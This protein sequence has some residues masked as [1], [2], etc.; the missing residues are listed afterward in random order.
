MIIGLMIT[1]FRGQ[2]AAVLYSRNNVAV[3]EMWGPIIDA[4]DWIDQMDTYGDMSGVPAIVLHVNSPGGYVTP[5]QELCRRVQKL[6]EKDGKV[7]VA[8]FD[9][10]A[11]SG[12]YYAAAGADKIVCSPG[13]MTG[14]IGVYMKHMEASELFSKIGV[15]FDTIRAGRYKAWGGYERPMDDHER[16]MVQSVIDD[17]Y[18]QFVEAVYT[19]RKKPLSDFLLR[20]PD[21]IRKQAVNEDGRP[22]YPFTGIV[23]DLLEEQHERTEAAKEERREKVEAEAKQVAER[24]EDATSSQLEEF[25]DGMPAG[26]SGIIAAPTTAADDLIQ[27]LA[28]ELAEGKIY[29]GRQAQKVGLVDSLGYLDDAIDTAAK[30]ANIRGEPNIIKR[31]KATPSL[32]DLITEK[33]SQF[34]ERGRVESPLQY[35]TPLVP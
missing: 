32:L 31:R 18:S 5:S 19:G 22:A 24:A 33:V 12:A 9:D 2:P 23:L 14:S 29:T 25:E 27:R 11:A 7:V 28:R 3:V 6:R 4:T 8:Y 17:T 10:V 30:L 15:S 34:S 26:V 1:A 20:D 21:E 13:S 16:E 35:R